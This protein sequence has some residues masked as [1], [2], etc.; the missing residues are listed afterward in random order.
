[1]N[2]T[3]E[4]DVSVGLAPVEVPDDPLMMLGRMVVLPAA[5]IL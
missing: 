5:V 3:S 1:M 4:T 2:P